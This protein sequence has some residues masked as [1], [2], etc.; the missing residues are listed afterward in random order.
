[1]WLIL[2][3]RAATA[4]ISKSPWN[5]TVIAA[6]LTPIV[7]PARTFTPTIVSAGTPA[8]AVKVKN[9]PSKAMIAI[10]SVCPTLWQEL[11]CARASV[12]Y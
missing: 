2:S 9:A 11:V 4:T 3:T 10:K 6:P 5:G 8:V 12:H 1:M 7:K